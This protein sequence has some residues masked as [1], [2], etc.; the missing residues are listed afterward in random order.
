MSKS[1]TPT[2]EWLDI[3]TENERTYFFENGEAYKIQNPK[4]VMI[5]ESGSHRVIAEDGGHWVAPTFNAIH[6]VPKNPDKVFEF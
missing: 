4:S 2:S 1:T 5:S 3:S 6:W